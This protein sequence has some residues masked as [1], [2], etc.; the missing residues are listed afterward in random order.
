[1]FAFFRKYQRA[2]FIVTTVVVII[3]FVFLGTYNRLG[4]TTKQKDIVIGK[5]IDDTDLTLS[6]V[7]GVSLFLANEDKITKSPLFEKLA[8]LFVLDT[9][10]LL[11]EKELKKD[12]EKRFDQIKSYKPYE[13]GNLSAKNVWN[14]FAKGINH[15][16]EIIQ[17]KNSFDLEAFK[18]FYKL[19]IKQKKFP[20][21]TL[22]RVLL[23]YAKQVNMMDPMLIRSDHRLFDFASFFSWFGENFTDIL[24]QFIININQFAK[25]EGFSVK[26]VYIESKKGDVL[27]SNLFKNSGFLAVFEEIEFFKRYMESFDG[28]VLDDLYHRE[29]FAASY[30][31]A[32]VKKY[33]LPKSLQL[34]NFNDFILLQ[35]YLKAVSK[36]KLEDDFAGIDEIIKNH[37]SLVEKNLSI[38]VKE[39]DIK[40]LKMQIAERELLNWQIENFDHLASKYNLKRARGKE[41]RFSV[42]NN[43]QTTKKDK[44]DS[45]SKG[46]M[47]TDEL[48]KKEVREKKVKPLNI[49]VPLKGGEE[50]FSDIDNEKLLSIKGKKSF[51]T[52]DHYFEIEVKE[53]LGMKVRS[54]E[55]AKG[56]GTLEYLLDQFLMDY[57]ATT[58]EELSKVKDKIAALAFIDVLKDLDRKNK[59][60][61]EEGK[62]SFDHYITCFLKNHVTDIKNTKN[63]RGQWKL[64]EKEMDLQKSKSDDWMKKEIFEKMEVGKKSDLNKE[65]TFFHLI[66]RKKKKPSFE[67]IKKTRDLISNDILSEFLIK[68]VK[69][70]KKLNLIKIDQ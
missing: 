53:D 19:Y 59:S 45:Y 61:W 29:I 50:I 66:S 49:S 39:V 57:S 65:N 32:K 25:S 35:Y 26:K 56:D 21:N 14:I 37:P 64:E 12:F 20:P 2:I 67:E 1:M 52:K 42:L 9:F 5:C 68:K 51:Q 30:E 16:L 58:S 41:Y 4:R 54:F 69:E 8:D 17:N 7:K 22:K 23:Y 28:L 38:E 18:S 60:K 24:S 6:R 31:V 43:L 11:Y 3:S 10:F 15:H 36:G 62:G 33:S 34:K 63:F 40:E 47:V 55:K 27:D 46:K 70:F 13:N 48:I 44:I